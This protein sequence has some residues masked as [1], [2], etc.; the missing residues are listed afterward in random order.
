M[1]NINDLYFGTIETLEHLDAKYDVASFGKGF[2]TGIFILN[3]KKTR[4]I[5]VLDGKDYY[6]FNFYNAK[7]H[8]ILNRKMYQQQGSKVVKQISPLSDSLEYYKVENNNVI[9]EKNDL[10]KINK[11]LNEEVLKD[12]NN[13]KTNNKKDEDELT[14]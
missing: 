12:L 8:P 9:F 7:L 11:Q 4:A 1:Y 2:E 10:I 14:K 13:N 6:I 3:N 5:N